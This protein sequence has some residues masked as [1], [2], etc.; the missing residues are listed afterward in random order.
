MLGILFDSRMQL[1][2][3]G[4]YTAKTEVTKY[5]SSNR[6]KKLCLMANVHLSINNKMTGFNFK[7]N[8]LNVSTRTG[9]SFQFN[10]T[11]LNSR[12]DDSILHK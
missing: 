4:P 8:L 10:S 12:I 5:R 3:Q 11:L 6:A 1:D 7:I 2:H 9:A